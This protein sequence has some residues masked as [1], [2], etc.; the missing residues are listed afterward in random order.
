MEVLG[1][2]LQY[3]YVEGGKK[4][5]EV[6][7]LTKKYDGVVA[8][9]NISFKVE[10]GEILGFLGPN[11]AGKT[12]TLRVITG[13]L[14]PTKGSCKVAGFNVEE[15][16]I[17]AK[18]RIGYLP[19]NNPLYDDMKVIEY[20]EFIGRLREV[21]NLSKRI[22]EVVDICSL[23]EVMGKGINELSRG[24]KQ[25]VGLAQSIIHNPD[26]LIMDEPTEGLDP[27]QKREV[28]ELIRELGKE[29]TVILSTHI[30]PEVEVT[31]D[32]VIIINK[33]KIVADG[34]KEEIHR[35]SR[36]KEVL[37][38]EL[39]AP[40]EDVL[41]TFEANEAIGNVEVKEKETSV[42]YEIET[43]RDLREDIFNL[44]VSHSWTL[45]EMQ[46][47]AVSLEDIFMELTSEK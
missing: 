43:T 34:P 46:R 25:R 39:R 40:K 38:V 10:K 26:I 30:L 31:C 47:K 6:K 11:G 27:N 17:E 9:D 16:P 37:R 2:P 1:P 14:P 32:R 7:N 22:K 35:M 5:I 12:T 33:G 44:A 23:Y 13:Y 4:M 8:I 24:Y 21:D 19:E 20:L 41:K 36:G 18:R 15:N 45:L 28:R 42:E 29:K 3:E